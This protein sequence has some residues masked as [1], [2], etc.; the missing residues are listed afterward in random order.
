MRYNRMSFTHDDRKNFL[1]T[2]KTYIFQDIQTAID[3]KANYLAALGL[4]TY[5]E[6][7][8]GMCCGDLEHNLGENYVNFIEHYFPSP[9]KT[10]NSKLS[11]LG[12]L[13]KV[14]RCGLVHEYFMKCESV[15]T[16]NKMLKCG[17]IY[18]T[19]NKPPL[20]FNVT[21]YFTDFKEAFHK[22]YNELIGSPNPT[23]ESFW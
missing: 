4:S 13:Y 14:V 2:L 19:T 10:L 7:L 17:I 21:Q 5:T 9:Y 16:A 6:N 12:G 8:G 11:G 15:V 22:Y 18:E 1:N 20:E 23:L 3:G